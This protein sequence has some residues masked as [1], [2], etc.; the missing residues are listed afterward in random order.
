MF[1]SFLLSKGKHFIHTM[2]NPRVIIEQ[3]ELEGRKAIS[4][5]GLDYFYFKGIP[6]AK[7]PLG[8]LRFKVF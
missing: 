5:N 3:G 2:S 7:P 8:E 4:A 1:Q 6:Y